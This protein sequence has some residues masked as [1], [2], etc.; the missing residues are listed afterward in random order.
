MIRALR[1]LCLTGGALLLPL[2][3]SAHNGEW[4]LAKCT[5][6]PGNGV[7]LTVTADAEANPRIKTQDDLVRAMK[8]LLLVHDGETT[9]D[10]LPLADKVEYG[11]DDRLDAEAPLGHTPEELAKSYTLLK[12]TATCR[13][14]PRRF[15]FRLPEKCPHTV[16][17]WLVDERLVK[18]EPRWVMLIGGDESPMIEVAPKQEGRPWWVGRRG[19]SPWIKISLAALAMAIATWVARKVMPD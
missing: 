19:L 15:T 6:D 4:L 9:R 5:I 16:V 13:L 7:T 10:F 1:V 18:Q 14:P 3:A 2:L 11:T 17:L 12:S 8:E